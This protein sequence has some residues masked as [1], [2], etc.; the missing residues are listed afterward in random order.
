MSDSTSPAASGDY[1]VLSE[2]RVPEGSGDVLEGAFADRLHE[3]EQHAGFRRLEVWRD[4]RDATRYLMM[5]WWAGP[6]D[7][8]TYMRSEEHRRSHARIPGAPHKP[9]GVRVEQFHV[10]AR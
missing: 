8:R 6:E 2:L 3:V 10:V 5:T 7:F 9:K 1:A 4:A